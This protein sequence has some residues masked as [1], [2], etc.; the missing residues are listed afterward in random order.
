ML[1]ACIL[2]YFSCAWN[3]WIR[4]IGSLETCLTRNLQFDLPFDLA[5]FV[6]AIWGTSRSRMIIRLMVK[7]PMASAGLLKPRKWPIIKLRGKIFFPL[8]HEDDWHSEEDEEDM[9]FRTNVFWLID[10]SPIVI[11]CGRF[12]IMFLH[13]ISL[14]KQLFDP[15]SCIQLVRITFFTESINVYNDDVIHTSFSSFFERVGVLLQFCFNWFVH[16]P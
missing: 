8:W 10:F 15:F 12:T 9:S 7:P 14:N 2:F 11:L 16:L 1:N 13:S 3:L 4:A 5:T 6:C